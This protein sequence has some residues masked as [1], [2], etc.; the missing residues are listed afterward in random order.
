[1]PDFH[2]KPKKPFKCANVSIHQNLDGRFWVL[3]SW[4]DYLKFREFLKTK[5]NHT[6]YKFKPI[7]ITQG[8]NLSIPELRN[9]HSHSKVFINSTPLFSFETRFN[10]A[11]TNLNRVS[12]ENTEWS[13]IY[14]NFGFKDSAGASLSG[15]RPILDKDW[16]TLDTGPN[17]HT[18]FT[19]F[20]IIM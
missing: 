14:E 17:P 13:R 1:M 10:K 20:G 2:G 3:N 15:G 4:Y 9:Q 16:I 8:L 7:K 5:S 11:Q 12:N 6:F 18:C 19:F